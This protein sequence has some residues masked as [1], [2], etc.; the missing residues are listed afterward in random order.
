MIRHVDDIAADSL[1]THKHTYRPTDT[2]TYR[3]THTQ[4]DNLISHAVLIASRLQYTNKFIYLLTR[5]TVCTKSRQNADGSH[6][7]YGNTS[8]L[9]NI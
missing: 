3:Q 4:R 7:Y 8:H 5:T 1:H 2:H 9:E 6:S